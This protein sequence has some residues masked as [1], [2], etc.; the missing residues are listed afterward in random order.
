MKLT[1][2]DKVT[3]EI[4][5]TRA[6]QPQQMDGIVVWIDSKKVRIKYKRYAKD[7][8]GY[9]TGYGYVTKDMSGIKKIR[10]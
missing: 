2:G 10:R 3:F 1:K 7:F 4:G 9:V 6:Y 8:P 5:A